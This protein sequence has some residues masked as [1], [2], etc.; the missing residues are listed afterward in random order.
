MGRL[1]FARIGLGVWLVVLG[2]LMSISLLSYTQGEYDPSTTPFNQPAKINNLGGPVGAGFAFYSI[3]VFGLACIMLPLLSFLWGIL[4]V[5]KNYSLALKI[6]SYALLYY[7][8]IFTSIGLFA[9]YS[10]NI[11]GELGNKIASLLRAIIPAPIIAII[12]FTSF[13][14]LVS[15]TTK[16]N[17]INH[18]NKLA[19]LLREWQKA[20]QEKKE[21]EKRKLIEEFRRKESERLKRLEEIRLSGNIQPGTEIRIEPGKKKNEEIAKKV[22]IPRIVRNEKIEVQQESLQEISKA[23]TPR[24]PE[25]VREEAQKIEQAPKTNE[26]E[27]LKKPQSA[28][29]VSIPPKQA[30]FVPTLPR[31]G[32]TPPPINYL[33]QGAQRREINESELAELGKTLIEKLES[34]GIEG[35][36]KSILPGP[37]ITRF[38][39]EPASGI[40]VSQIVNLEDDLA[41]ALKA[42]EIRIQAPVPGKGVVGI[43]VPNKNPEQVFLREIIESEQFKKS[44][45]PLTVALGKRVDG[46]PFV[47]DIRKL[48]HLLVAG[49]TGSGKSVGI[50]VMITSIIYKSN[51]EDVRFILIDPKRI[52]LTLY[53]GIPFLNADV[54]V[55]PK[56]AAKILKLTLLEMNQ[57]YKLLQEKGVREIDEYNRAI[58][59]QEER[60]LPYLVVIIDELADLM[61]VASKDV[62]EPIVRLAQLARA[63]G[64]HLVVATQRPSVDVVTGLIKANFPARIAFRVRSRTDSRTIIDCNGAER[65]MGQ[66]DMLFL[67]PGTSVPIRIHG[68]FVSTAE[69]QKIVEY[70]KQYEN[71]YKE[72]FVEL[73]DTTKEEETIEGELDEL[74]WEAAR[75]VVGYRQGSTSYLQRKLRIGYTRAARLM[76]QLEHY[77]I[78]G[79]LDGSKPREILIPSLEK[80][81][82]LRNNIE[83]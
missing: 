15:I 19:K 17:I 41:L 1:N 66:G 33:T 68:A 2:V 37:L 16:F 10:K 3:K 30:T 23:E 20:R 12:L 64:I 44:T 53:N 24:A 77:G 81:E 25:P 31:T 57:R 83:K 48:P 72:D 61:M 76:E 36:L 38:E 5:G 21:A 40:K 28:P 45:S 63:V 39:F 42:P 35:E 52:E 13:L 50:N 82:E 34:F 70:L 11:S 58:N 78:V 62:E 54:V 80:L 60:K 22:V 29:V 14:A 49:A 18:M 74:F 55:E 59:P 27:E 47:V 69:T 65:L 26:T 7:I 67:P 56:D 46:T 79:P 4:A 9:P 32:Y 73:K 71:P 43:E 6:T 51:P 8:V 75:I